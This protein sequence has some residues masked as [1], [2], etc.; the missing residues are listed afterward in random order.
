MQDPLITKFAQKILEEISITKIIAYTNKL[1][2]DWIVQHTGNCGIHTIMTDVGEEPMHIGVLFRLVAK[3]KPSIWG[4]CL[5]NMI[6]YWNDFLADIFG[7]RLNE[8]FTGE[9]ILPDNIAKKIKST[10]SLCDLAGSNLDKIQ[11]VLL[12]SFNFLPHKERLKLIEQMLDKS[13]Q[14]NVISQITKAVEVRNVIQHHNSIVTSDSLKRLG[15][16][17][18]EIF[19]NDGNAIHFGHGDQIQLTLAEIMCSRNALFNAACLF[20]GEDYKFKPNQFTDMQW[21]GEEKADQNS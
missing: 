15:C 6:I 18:I 1:G 10:I 13:L 20:Y 3:I 5:C 19:N 14:I 11:E 4:N 16:N 17:T 7:K 8:H 9:N 12:Y 2:E 21:F